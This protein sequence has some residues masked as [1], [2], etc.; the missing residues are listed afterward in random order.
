MSDALPLA[1]HVPVEGSNVNLACFEVAGQIY[2][3]EVEYLREIVRMQA[4]TPLPDAPALIEGV[5]DLRGSVI[6]VVDLARCLGLA[7]SEGGSASR[8]VIVEYA[9]LAV[10]LGVDAATDVMALASDRLEAVPAL[11][12]KAGDRS[13]SHVV[14]REGESPVMVI[15]LERLIENVSR[16]S[17]A[18][19]GEDGGRG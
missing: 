11:A 4:I 14:R 16:S 6:P 7:G 18:P 5:V 12:T 13:V 2:A 8:I 3:L 9:G 10:G 19:L 15:S 1:A 17:H